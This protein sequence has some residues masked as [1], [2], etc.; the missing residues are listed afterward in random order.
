MSNVPFS[1]LIKHAKPA[2][3]SAFLML[4][5]KL[6]KYKQLVTTSVIQ[7]SEYLE[8]IS[9]IES[10]NNLFA[11]E[12]LSYEFSSKVSNHGQA[13]WHPPCILT[14]SVAMSCMQFSDIM[15]HS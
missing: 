12:I 8:S 15:V 4:A 14:I 5:N 6:R 3:F 13:Y 2:F 7:T 11:N 1:N 9:S 10:A